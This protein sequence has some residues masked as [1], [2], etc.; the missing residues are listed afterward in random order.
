MQFSELKYP[1]DLKKN[2]LDGNI[3]LAYVDEGSG[4][5]T[6]LFIHGL[7]SY[8]PAWRRNISVLKNNFRCIAVDLPGYGKSSKNIH[9]GEMNFYSSV[10]KDFITRLKLKKVTIAGH[11]MGGQIAINTALLYPETV[12]KLILIAPAGFE[13]FSADEIKWSKRTYSAEYFAS[14]TPKQIE[15][16]VRANFYKM[17]ADAKFM[18]TDRIAVRDSDEFKNYCNVVSNSLCGM[19]DNPVSERLRL[20]KQSTLVVFGLNDKFIPNRL[21]HKTTTEAIAR[22]GTEKIY[23][24]KLVLIPRCGHFIPYEK[25]DE[26]NKEVLNFMG[27]I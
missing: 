12:Y 19:F 17:P 9:S 11:S 18:I 24:S 20:I 8:I 5:Q 10:L 15:L 6:I 16:N 14:T 21:F 4:E 23:D 25:P 13:E 1:F 3:Q 27:I 7:G 26:F 2:L 22:K